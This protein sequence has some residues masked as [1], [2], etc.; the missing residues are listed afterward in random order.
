MDLQ[1][2]FVTFNLKKKH[3]KRIVDNVKLSFKNKQK[4]RPLPTLRTKLF[5]KGFKKKGN[6]GNM[7][8]IHANKNGVK[9][10]NKVNK[11]KKS[12]EIDKGIK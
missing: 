12:E 2:H 1:N 10:W 7:Y 4:I 6:D 11:I 5:K 8:Y 9:T 3:A